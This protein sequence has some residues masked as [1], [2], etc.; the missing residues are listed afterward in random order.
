M[1]CGKSGCL[2]LSDIKLRLS[3]STFLVDALAD[4]GRGLYYCISRVLFL[5]TFLLKVAVN[6]KGNR[7]A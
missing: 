2:V 1:I 5:E 3:K 7:C 4:R 6:R